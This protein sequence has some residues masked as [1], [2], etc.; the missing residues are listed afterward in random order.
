MM[1][2]KEKAKARRDQESG[3]EKPEETEAAE[4]NLKA[5]KETTLTKLAQALRQIEAA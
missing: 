4:K 5:E 1:D 2:E 3:T